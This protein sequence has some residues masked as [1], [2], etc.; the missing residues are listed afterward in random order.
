MLLIFMSIE[1]SQLVIQTISLSKGGEIF[2]LDMG[3]PKIEDLARQ[4]ISLQG[5]KIKR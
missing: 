1:A 5:L 2:L 3:K 4:M